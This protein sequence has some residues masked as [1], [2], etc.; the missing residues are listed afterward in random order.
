MEEIYVEY[1]KCVFNYLFSLT[2]NYEVAEEL[3]QETFYSA[4]K[5]IN[6][7]RNESSLKNWLYKIAKNKW[8]DYC[9]KNKK[10]MQIN[11]ES[12]SEKNFISQPF[13]DDVADRA[14]LIEIYKKI[15]VLD[16]KSKEVVYLRVKCEFTFKEI[17]I[18]MG[19][20]EEWARTT[21]FRAKNK[22]KE[23]IEYGE[24]K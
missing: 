15:H 13:E 18:I 22:L 7:F 23:S 11:I 14:E 16:E 21:Y 9:K 10:N 5:N 17:G 4:M 6:K 19:Q 1:S 24:K 12:I 20:S 2:N 3:L 8:L